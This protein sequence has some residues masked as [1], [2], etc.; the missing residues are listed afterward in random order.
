MIIAISAF[1]YLA[2]GTAVTAFTYG[3]S[4]VDTVLDVLLWPVIIYY[5]WRYRF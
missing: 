3:R 1:V 2:I 5:A 4:V